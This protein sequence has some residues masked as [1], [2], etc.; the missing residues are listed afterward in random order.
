MVG[1][2]QAVARQDGHRRNAPW[3]TAADFAR[4]RTLH[5]GR[6]EVLSRDLEDRTWVVA[7]EQDVE[8]PRYYRYDRQTR[9]TTPLLSSAPGLAGYALAPMSPISF[10]ARDGLTLQGYLT[11]PPGRPPGGL[12]MVLLVHGGPWRRDQ[13]GFDHVAQWLASRGYAVLQVNFRGSTGYG[14]AHLEAG[15]R[16]WGGRMLT[17]LVDGKA[18]AVREGY[19]DPGKVCV[20]GPSYGGYATL[21]ALAFTPTEFVCGIAFAAPTDLAA[22]V[23]S[24]SWPHTPY[25]EARVGRPETD[26]TFLRSRSPLFATDRIVAPLLVIH[27]ANDPNVDRLHGDRLVARLRAEGKPV[28]YLVLPDEGHGLRRLSSRLRF[29]AAVE[30]FLA[31]HLGGDYEPPAAE[32]DWGPL[33]R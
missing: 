30:D 19:A 3:E 7:F 13:W 25:W 4:L 10:R 33:A 31:R 22:L 29:F 21:S 18:W 23:R 2:T 11:L 20:M 12:P 15:T 16:E 8:P 14:K 24:R 1:F 5:P 26:E 32:E 27:G 6:L 9:E 28:D 17:D